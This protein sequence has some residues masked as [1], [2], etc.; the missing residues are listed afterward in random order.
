MLSMT[1]IKSTARAIVQNPQDNLVVKVGTYA[2][3]LLAE[4]AFGR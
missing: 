1:P 4:I 3:A 2:T